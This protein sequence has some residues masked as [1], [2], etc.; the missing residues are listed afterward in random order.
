MTDETYY[1]RL[2]EGLKQQR[3]FIEA[4]HQLRTAPGHTP[5][6]VE[7]LQ[8]KMLATLAGAGDGEEAS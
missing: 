8:R 2:A 7:E 1:S 3:R 4:M 5:K 6:E